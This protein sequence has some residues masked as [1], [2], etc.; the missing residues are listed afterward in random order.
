M[1]QLNKSLRIVF[2]LVV[3]IGASLPA[4]ASNIDL[5]TVPKRDSVQL[6]IYNS[7]DITLVRET[8]VVTFKKGINPL[9]FSWANTLI[10][11]SSVDLKF[12]TSADKLEVEDTTFPHDKSQMLYWNVKSNFDGEATIQ[13]SYFTSGITW[14]ADYTAIANTN[15]TKLDLDGFVRVTNNSGEEYEN[16]HVRLVVGTINLV[17]KIAE[18]AKIPIGEVKQLNKEELGEFRRMAGR[19]AMDRVAIGGAMS[20]TSAPSE[21]EIFKEGLSEYFIYAIEGTETIPNGWSKRMRSFKGDGVPIKIQYRYRPQEYGDQ[22]VRLYL[23][24]NNKES[25]LGTTPLPDGV[26]RVF[27]DNGRDG[28]SYLTQQSIKYV[29]IGERIEL[30]LGSDPNVVFEL[31]KQRASRDHVWMQVHGTNT[32]KEV[33]GDADVSEPNMSVVG[34]DDHGIY[35]QEIR[36]DTAKLIDVEIRRTFGGHVVFRSELNPK[37]HDYQTVEF[38]TQVAPGARKNLRYE[39]VQHQGHNAKQNNVTLET[40]AVK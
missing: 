30:N 32:F 26:V 21:K 4:W 9:E 5:S 31:T 14:S 16:A 18:L 2:V 20:P 12:V 34:W 39:L 1:A 19:Q 8:R 25:E 3:A 15:E 36:N 24:T 38:T 13:I 28:L 17:E 23:T 40:A 33:G 22:L 10:D 11:P 35:R 7:E 27:R 6:T 29:P 37:L